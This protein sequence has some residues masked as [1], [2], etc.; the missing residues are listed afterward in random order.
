[1]KRKTFGLLLC[2]LVILSLMLSS[3]AIINGGT[4]YDA[5]IIVKNSSKA[6][7]IY[8]GEVKGYGDA[9]INVR[10]KDANK[11]SVTVKE[12]GQQEEVFDYKSRTFRTGAFICSVLFWTGLT[13]TGIPLPWGTVID[14]ASGAVWKPDLNETGIS[15]VS[16][17]KFDYH[18]HYQYAA[19]EQPQ[20]TP[21]TDVLSDVVYL[22]NGSVVK[23]IIIEQVPNV[24]LKIKTSNGSI[25]VF[26]FADIEKITKE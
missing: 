21:A 22:K 6:Q 16:A 17:K 15:Q 10:R 18:L 19:G 20:S 25:F 12:E 9:H 13:P 1:M 26:P 11:F 23:G 5:H 3:C 2:S 7:I 4:T 8:R 24:Q 14:L